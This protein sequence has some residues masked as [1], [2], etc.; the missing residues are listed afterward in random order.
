MKKQVRKQ[1]VVNLLLRCSVREL[2]NDLLNNVNKGGL[3]YVWNDN[4]LLAYAG[5]IVC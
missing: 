2:H 1:K 5:E 4:K 3:Q